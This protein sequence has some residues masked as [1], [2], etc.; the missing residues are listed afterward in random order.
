MRKLLLLLPVLALASCSSGHDLMS[1]KPFRMTCSEDGKD[2]GVVV[3]SPDLPQATVLLPGSKVM[4]EVT[5]ELAVKTPVRFEIRR[6]SADGMN[7]VISINRETAEVSFGNVHEA[8][9]FSDIKPI[10]DTTKCGFET[11]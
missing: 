9:G 10:P 3:V 6:K 5:Y 2:D 11:L 8:V 7:H 4:P 1:D